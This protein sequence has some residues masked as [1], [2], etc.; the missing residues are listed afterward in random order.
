MKKLFLALSLTFWLGCT[1]NA[2]PTN[3]EP[4]GVGGGGALFFPTI[5]PANDNEFYIAC[6]MSEMFHSSDFGLN[7][8]QIHFAKLQVFNTSTYE[9]T[10]N[11]NI[12][13]SVYNDGNSGYPVRTLDG[14]NTWEDLPGNPDASEQVY[15]LE[16]NFANPNQLIMGYYGA[17]YV[18]QDKGNTFQLVKNAANNGV[19]L[20]IGGV[21]FSGQ[22]IFIGT[23]EG[24]LV[25][26]NGG[27]SFSMLATTGIPA[28]EAIWSFAA[29]KSGNVTR[30]FCITGTA[31]SLY[32]GIMPWDYWGLAKGV[33]ALD[34]NAAGA[35]QWVA[36]N[37]GID[38]NNDFVMYV[39]MAENDVNTVYLAGTDQTTNAPNIIKT[40][41]AGSSWAKMFQPLNNQNITT[42]WEGH[43]GDRQW[44][45]DET[46]FG[47]GVAPNNAN[48]IIISGFGCVHTSADGGANWKQAYVNVNDQHPAGNFTPKY[49]DYHSIGIENTTCWQVHWTDVNNVFACFSD[50]KGIRSKNAGLAWSFDYTGH[51]ANSM[52]RLVEAPNGTLFAGTS[53]IH[54]MYQST[55]LQDAQLDANDNNGKIIYSTDKGATWQNVH[56]F[57]HPVFW[58]ALDPNNAN[59]MYASVIHY[60][61]GS[62]Q[63]GIWV[64]NNLNSLG[65]STWTKLPNPPRTEGHPASIVVLNDGKV[66]CTYSG[67]RG[68]SGFTASSGVFIYTPSTNSWA[69]VSASGMYYWTKDII[70]DPSD[71]AQNTW[72]VGVFSGWGGAP[73]GLGGL[74][75]TT[76]RGANWTKLTGSQ[77]DRVTSITFH[78]LDNKQAYLTTET[79]GLWISNN[80]NTTTPTWTLIEAYPFRQPERV[81]FNPFNA[82]ELWVTSFGNGLK[83]ANLNNVG[84][85]FSPKPAP[86][87]QV[88]PNPAQHKLWIEIGENAKS[89]KEIQ[90]LD[91]QGKIVAHLPITNDKKYNLALEK[92][93]A[94]VYFVR[95]GESIKKFI[96]E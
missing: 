8:D 1:S 75:K 41:N 56:T 50:I 5:N 12:A 6:D 7:Y 80:M 60:G 19:G 83:I 67:R 26:T 77:F 52:Y 44:G 48:K 85:D 4:R 89:C 38:F 66:V 17:I 34:Y 14:G 21:F 13:Y 96:K 46:C 61:G 23:N 65:A 74:Y 55:R 25:S 40:T 33:Y 16:A 90:V 28:N 94:G 62:G 22:N 69:D 11:P 2:Q 49:Q 42:G 15:K 76:N 57:N 87:F 63:G 53:D 91:L 93:P 73:N 29:A 54:D 72:Y 39:G 92:Y 58:V 3:F 81:F 27:T 43:L 64:T 18:S 82:K 32:N 20:I 79:Q 31:S 88:Y 59:K 78:P 45:Y 24:V 71:A 95:I 68:N 10:N 51:N 70:L 35:N 36:K 37:T 30:F 86:S 9:F 84:I 47:I